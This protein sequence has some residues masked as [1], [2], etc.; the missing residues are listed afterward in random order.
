MEN[1]SSLPVDPNRN[2]IAKIVLIGSC[3]LLAIC[4]TMVIIT[5]YIHDVANDTTVSTVK[6]VFNAVLPV[7]ATWIGTVI[8][9]Y[10][11]RDNFEAASRQLNSMVSKI[12]PDMYKDVPVKQVMIDFDTMLKYC[13]GTAMTT[14]GDIEND[15][16]NNSDKSRLP[17]VDKDS[18]PLYIMHKDEFNNLIQADPANKTKTIASF[19]LYG[20]NQPKG[21]VVISETATLKDAQQAYSKIS[22]CQDVFVTKGGTLTEKLTG[23]LTDSRILNFLQ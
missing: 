7:I 21:F 11:G 15:F 8:A 20:F 9:F 13:K 2:T 6:D 19:N 10:F 17:I 5:A 3:A 14:L 1:D 4:L 23:W 12:T 16:L 22:T 18:N